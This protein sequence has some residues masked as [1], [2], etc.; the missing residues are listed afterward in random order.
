MTTLAYERAINRENKI[1][2]GFVYSFPFAAEQVIERGIIYGLYSG[3]YLN[4]HGYL[5][6]IESSELANLLNDYNAKIADLTA[7]EANVVA[8]IVSKRYLAGVDKLIHDQKLE[9]KSAGITAD[10]EMW[11]AKIAALS[12]DRAALATMAAKV[13]V[14]TEKTEA[15]ISELEAYIEIEG[16]K[17]SE[18]DIEIAEKEIQS[19]KIDIE[20]LNVANSVLKIQTDTVIAA[21]RLIDIDLEKS[22]TKV[23]IAHT[24]GNIAKIDLLDNELTRE[25]AQTTIME[26]ERDLALARSELATAKSEATDAEFE[27]Y[28]TT[29]PGQSDSDKEKKLESMNQ[30]DAFRRDDLAQRKEEKDLSRDSRRDESTL[31]LTLA[32]KDATD[33]VTIDAEK[34]I[35]MGWRVTD[36]RAETEAAVQ[37]AETLAAANIVS[38]LTHTVQKKAAT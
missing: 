17:L 30:K 36:R 12:V 23:D 16:I 24:E 33:Q 37:V 4:L 14:E 8:D 28:Q 31:G 25:Q 34:I 22:R 20:I 9:T 32:D 21:T 35:S 7:A 11:T 2:P 1:W 19:A 15:K 3:A 10:D 18:V 26:G 38:T 13:V 5:V 6:E 29:L 27:F